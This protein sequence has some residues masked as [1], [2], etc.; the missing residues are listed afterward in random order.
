M[1]RAEWANSL[2]LQR[3]EALAMTI[4]SIE[5][6][7]SCNKVKKVTRVAQDLMSCPPETNAQYLMWS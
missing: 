1:A 5:Q 2:E 4:L 6:Y 7:L 3:E